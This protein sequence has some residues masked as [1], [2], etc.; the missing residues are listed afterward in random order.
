ME[1]SIGWFKQYRHVFA[2]YCYLH[3]LYR[4]GILIYWLS[5]VSIT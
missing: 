1:R 5:N 4:A 3:F 2:C